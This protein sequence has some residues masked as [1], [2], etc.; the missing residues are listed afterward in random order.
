MRSCATTAC[1]ASGA[2][3]AL[4]LLQATGLD[5]PFLI[6]S[7]GIGEDVAVAAMKAGRERFPDQG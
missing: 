7:A 1:R 3:E 6:V 5:V 4:E 2:P